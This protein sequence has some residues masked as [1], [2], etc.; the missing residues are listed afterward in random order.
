MQCQVLR[1]IS[2]AFVHEMPCPVKVFSLLLLT[3]TATQTGAMLSTHCEVSA[4]HQNVWL[5]IILHL[6]LDINQISKN[7]NIRSIDLIFKFS[8][9]FFGEFI[10]RYF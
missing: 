1:F 2:T 10:L 6:D 4:Q 8:V 3:G 9:K 7:S 5:N